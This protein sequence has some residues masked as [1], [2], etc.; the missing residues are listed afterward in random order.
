MLSLTRVNSKQASSYYTADD[1][2][3]QD[4]GH[5]HGKLAQTLG[6]NGTIKEADFQSLIA[7]KDPND[8]FIIQSGGKD[9]IH[10]A[11]VDLTFSA[12]KSVSIAGLVLDDKRVLAAHDQAVNTALDY[13]EKNYTNVRLKKKQQVK[14]EFSGNMLAAKFRHI[15]SRE[16]DPQLH[17]HCLVMNFSQRKNKAMRAMDYQEIYQYKMLLGQLYRSELALNL[18]ELGYQIDADSKGLFEIKNIPDQLIQEFSKRSE[19]VNQR[20]QELKKQYPEISDAE[21]KAKATLETRKVKDEP[22]K[23]ELRK[24]W[25]S[26]L[27][28]LDMNKQELVA[29]INNTTKEREQELTKSEK[30]QF[31][32][33]A[34]TIATEHEAVINKEDILRIAG[35]L[36]LGKLRIN[37]LETEL[38]KL[39]DLIELEPKR[40]TTPAIAA[41]ERGIVEKVQNGKNTLNP[42][43]DKDSIHKEIIRYEL[44]HGFKLTNG[45][46]E[47]VIHILNSTDRIIAIQGDAGTGKTT[48]LDAVRTIAEKEQK[49]II[50]LSFTGKAASEIE[51]ASQIQSRTL[52]S[53]INSEEHLTNTLVVVDEASMLSIKDMTA[54]LNKC[55]ESTKLILIGD[56]K[57]LQT[58]GQGKIFTSL[59]EKQVISTVR[60]KEVQRQTDPEYKEIVNILNEKKLAEAFNQLNNSGRIHEIKDHNK[61]LATITQQ[62]LK[63]PHETI[64]VTAANKDREKL[65]QLIRNQLQIINL[66]S[67]TE[68]VYI[69]RENK[70]LYGEEKY[71][72]QSYT[73]GDL[74]VA[75]KAGIIGKS[76]AEAKIIAVNKQ[77]HEL[78]VKTKTGQSIK[79]DLKTHGDSLQVYTQ[80]AKPFAEGDKI[81]FLKNDRS[82]KIKNGQ[83][84]IIQN[85]K[86]D[87]SMHIKLDNGK[88][89]TIN[90]SS[91]YNYIA[92]GYALTDYKSQ[93]QTAKHVIYHAD[94]EKRVDFNQAY[95]GITRGKKSIT[96]ITNNKSVLKE[97]SEIERAKTTSLIYNLEKRFIINSRTYCS[98]KEKIR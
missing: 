22:S 35:K 82:L 96:I 52:A 15:S 89:L 67:E 85:I 95:V 62:Y 21:L 2:Y 26:R 41:M 80:S 91:Q 60:M 59:Q 37:E 75:N 36:S 53:L 87:K 71:Y 3:L 47:A 30:Q 63:N 51:E 40:Y 8:R 56:T 79:I 12:P 72:G 84:G 65:N 18:K 93:G 33:Q 28:A 58:I 50:G 76:G 83:T 74:I 7:G 14:S 27:L 31:L 19:Q 10:T 32:S 54:L 66:I 25:D 90:P 34:I 55:D 9:H 92:H 17:T 24:A 46:K 39:K 73:P 48:M 38:G 94:T 45:Q 49:P 5:W 11:G 42:I 13:I 1:Y 88:E 64:I 20:F 78:M 81:L 69:T 86:P 6:F 61:R 29:A 4:S 57:Q 23:D 97:K 77:K 43:L 16:L 68:Q 98:S 70:A 44:E